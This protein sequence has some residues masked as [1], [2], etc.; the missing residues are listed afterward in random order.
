MDG[1]ELSAPANSDS[2]KRYYA[3]CKEEKKGENPKGR[4]KKWKNEGK[5]QKRKE[6]NKKTKKQKKEEKKEKG[7]R[8]GKR[9]KEKKLLTWLM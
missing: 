5:K 1:K 8:E 2:I 7:K 4:L 3:W 6:E 9:E